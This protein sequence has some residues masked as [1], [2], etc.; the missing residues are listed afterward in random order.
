MLVSHSPADEPWARWIATALRAAGH[1]VRRT[2][3]GTAFAGHLAEERSSSD[4]PVL[5]LL[6]AEHRGTAADWSQLAALHAG[7]SASDGRL[8]ALRLDDCEVPPALHAVPCPS[9]HGLDE[10]DALE[11][12]L[13]LVGGTQTTTERCPSHERAVLSPRTRGT[14]GEDRSRYRTPR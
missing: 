13:L 10:E 7:T 11:L 12:V 2:P 6:S 9:L 1:E 14:E 3:A 5:V 4:G 8:I